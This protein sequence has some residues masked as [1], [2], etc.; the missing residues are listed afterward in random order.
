MPEEPEEIPVATVRV[1]VAVAVA[2]F[3]WG[4]PAGRARRP[5]D[6]WLVVPPRGQG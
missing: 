4:S 1:A 6:E 2:A 3:P 5:A